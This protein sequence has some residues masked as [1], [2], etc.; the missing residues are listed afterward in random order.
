M[1][2]SSRLASTFI[3]LRQLGDAHSVEQYLDAIQ[4]ARDVGAGEAYA[5]ACLG[6]DA[7]AIVKG[8]TEDDGESTLRAAERLLRSRG[9]DPAK[10]DYR[11]SSMRLRR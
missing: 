2:R 3:A 4:A 10:A 8:V 7:D 6:V 11:C 1:R 9:V 5:S